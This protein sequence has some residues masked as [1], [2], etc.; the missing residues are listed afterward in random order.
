MSA[1]QETDRLSRRL[2]VLYGELGDLE[3]ECN[4][5]GGFVVGEPR[6]LR[7]RS[8]GAEIDELEYKLAFDDVIYVP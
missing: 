2:D 3:Q 7:M 5:S 8:L 4:S 1:M 6:E